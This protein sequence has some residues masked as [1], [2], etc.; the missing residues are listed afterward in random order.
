MLWA[1]DYMGVFRSVKPSRPKQ[2][3][4]ADIATDLLGFIRKQFYGDAPFKKWAQDQRFLF[5]NVVTWPAR[6]LND[7]AVSLPPERYKK[8]LLDIFIDIQRHGQ[9]GT[10]KYW[11]G[12]L[13]HCVQE[14]FKIH[15]EEYYEEG[16]SIRAALERAQMAFTRA[17][18]TQKTV[19]PV[20]DLARVNQALQS[21]TRSLRKKPKK[22]P[23]QGTL[24]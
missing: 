18:E 16:K 2:E 14:H 19:D 12:Y 21:P 23:A 8:I 7:K 24:F 11:P 17:A 9:T 6:W 1:T 4:P 3:I 20:A 5:K 13:A 10:I 22:D 15:G